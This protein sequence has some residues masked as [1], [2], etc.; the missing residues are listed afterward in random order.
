L[1]IL[2]VDDDA[3]NVELFEAT[4]RGDGHEMTIARDGEAGQAR[5]LAERF[6]LILLDIQ[7]PRRTGIEICQALRAAGIRTPI[8]ALSASILPDEIA[9][10]KNVG[11]DQFIGKPTAPAKLRAVVRAFAPT[12]A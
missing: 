1:R 5:G 4:L 10:T 6:D 8:V 9:R 2:L 11:F 3:L 7:L 12:T